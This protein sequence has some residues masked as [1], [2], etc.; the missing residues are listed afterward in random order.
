MRLMGMLAH[1]LRFYDY[2]TSR[3]DEEKNSCLSPPNKKHLFAYT[4]R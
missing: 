1:S 2:N 3:A 4:R